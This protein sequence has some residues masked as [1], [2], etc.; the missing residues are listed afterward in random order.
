MFLIR[1][2]CLITISILSLYG[3]VNLN[4]PDSIIKNEPLVFT[5]EVYGKSIKF[6]DMSNIDGNSVQEISSSSST[7]IINGK[8][9]KK[10]KKIYSLYSNKN[11]KF[12]SLEFIVDS[13]SIYT[14]EKEIEILNPQKTK[15]ELFDLTIKSNK[16]ELF[17]GE[18]LILTLIFKYKKH[19]QIVDLNFEKPVFDDFWY[20]QLNDTKQYDE[21]EYSVQELKFL[22]F[23]LKEGTLTITPLNIQ[24][25]I[26]DARRN[27]F[28]LFSNATSVVKVYSNELEFNVKKLPSNVNLIGDFDIKATADK[29]RIKNGEA[30]SYKLEIKGSGNI[31]DIEDIKLNIKNATIYEN[32]PIRKSSFIENKYRGTYTKVFSI[33]PND[34]LVIPKITLEYYDKNLNQVVSKQTK[35]FKIELLKETVSQNI[36]KLEKSNDEIERKE[37]VKVVEKSSI[38]DNILYFSLGMILSALTLGLYLYVINSKK[39]K[40]FNETP[41]IKKVKASKTKEELLKVLVAYIK[42][43]SQL[44]VLIFKLE[45]SEEI[46]VLKKD[47]IKLL[48]QIDIKR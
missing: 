18:D 7:Q 21:G 27:S 17:V 39:E 36:V 2:I 3:N 15:S 6:P 48:K 12:P 38:K 1:F 41:L 31:D 26:I 45:K 33:I 13:K 16:K 9:S 37:V 25:Q 29:T 30:V 28:S 32:K 22:L 10:I 35:S 4:I 5:I 23:P 8:I 47:I 44:D 42:I 46:F 19:S 43:D 11:I 20:K 40:K 24:A 34:S 14:N